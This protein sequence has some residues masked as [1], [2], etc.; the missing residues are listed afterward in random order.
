M[1]V[2]PGFNYKEINNLSSDKSY[3][4]RLCAKF[5]DAT[6]CSDEVSSAT[7]GLYTLNYMNIMLHV[8]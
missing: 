7:L 3:R 8:I 4:F 5:T 6:L 1:T 2:G